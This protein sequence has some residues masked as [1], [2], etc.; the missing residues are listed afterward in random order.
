MKGRGGFQRR[1]VKSASYR[2]L[3][4][5]VH[6]VVCFTRDNTLE[7][8]RGIAKSRDSSSLLHPLYRID[9]TNRSGTEETVQKSEKRVFRVSEGESVFPRP[10]TRFPPLTRDVLHFTARFAAR[11]YRH[12]SILRTI[13][14]SRP[15]RIFILPL[16][17]ILHI[18]CNLC[19]LVRL[20][21]LACINETR[22]A[23]PGSIAESNLRR[24]VPGRF[25]KPRDYSNY[26]LEVFKQRHLRYSNILDNRY[27]AALELRQEFE[28]R[29]NFFKQRL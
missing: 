24:I 16:R 6:R 28:Q 14:V 7:G 29:Y 10:F 15:F 11:Q 2:S 21:F 12:G 27:G 23:F 8:Q 9:K 1:L 13:P 20:F 4:F 18:E 26:V 5:A 25:V 3:A 17:D 19:N 22:K